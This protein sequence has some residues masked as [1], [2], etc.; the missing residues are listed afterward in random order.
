MKPQQP[1][2]DA[3]CAELFALLSDYLDGSLDP[4]LCAKLQE[5]IDHCPPCQGFLASLRR[6]VDWCRG[7]QGVKLSPQ[8]AAQTRALLLEECRRALE[9]APRRKRPPKPRSCSHCE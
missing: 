7:N 9:G 6:T 5:H 1:S 4:E 8:L 3:K 2:A